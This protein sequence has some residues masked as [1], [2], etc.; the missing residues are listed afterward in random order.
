[1]NSTIA[2]PP[3]VRIL[4][5]SESVEFPGWTI[6]RLQLEFFLGHAAEEPFNLLYRAYPG[7][8]QYRTQGLIADP[9]TLVLF[10][11]QRQIIAS[12]TLVRRE[13]YSIPLGPYHGAYWFDPRSVC[14]FVPI[15]VMA[16][17]GVWPNVTHLENPRWRLDPASYP[18]FQRLLRGVATPV[19]SE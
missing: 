7:C 16:I 13:A 19:I 4:P 17:H 14:I 5:M 2:L 15:S 18:N 11:F 3:T 1:M 6:P 10:Q 9:G 8:Y 12:A